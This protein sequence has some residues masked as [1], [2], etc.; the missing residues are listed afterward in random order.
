MFHFD[1]YKSLNKLL[2]HE[3]IALLIVINNI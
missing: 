3:K 1:T 2:S